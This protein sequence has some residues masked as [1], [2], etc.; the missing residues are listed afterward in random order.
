MKIIWY[1]TAT[2]MIES[3]GEGLLFDPFFRR[4]KHLQKPPL[5]KFC[6]VDYIF[7]THSHFD[8]L[9]D[10]P[11]I[12]PYTEAQVFGTNMTSKRLENQGVSKSQII[13][14]PPYQTIKTRSAE[15]T[16]YPSKH[17]KNDV[18]IILKTVAWGLARLMFKKAHDILKLH[19]DFRMGGE[20][21]AY[22]LKI[23]GKS[24]LIFGSAGIDEDVSLP[25]DVD[26]LIWAYQG[27]LRMDKY[28]LPIIEKIKPK[29]V[30]LDHF[31]DAF[32]P[33]T[34]RV[35]TKKFVKAMSRRH[36]E[37]KVIVPKYQET[38]KF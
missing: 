36:P 28:S 10:V 13:A 33:I 14:L 37:I 6:D 19:N 29:I 24:I 2:I 18:C 16:P 35:N 7:N 31:D 1:G 30:V 17:V 25:Q 9:C 34:G 8:H 5:A 38:M 3:K 23:E 26:I 4:N 15:I 21:Y 27:R 22:H 32:P 12:L 20:I 11:K